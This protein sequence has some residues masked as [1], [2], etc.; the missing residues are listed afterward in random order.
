[1]VAPAAI[2][3]WS[4]IE[5]LSWLPGCSIDTGAGPERE[6]LPTRL[7]RA[8]IKLNLKQTA[9]LIPPS[10]GRSACGYRRDVYNEHQST[11]QTLTILWRTWWMACWDEWRDCLGR[12]AFVVTL[13]KEQQQLNAGIV[14]VWFVLCKP[15]SPQ[16]WML[17]KIWSARLNTDALQG[18]TEVMSQAEIFFFLFVSIIMVVKVW[19]THNI[20]NLF[21]L[22][23]DKREMR[24]SLRRSQALSLWIAWK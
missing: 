4:L 6:T 21:W 14:G 19:T 2:Q 18:N 22:S 16:W 15:N 12:A 17:N 3:C 9:A 20:N 13:L 11:P 10:G 7:T 8:I 23:K 24:I 1:M 5:V